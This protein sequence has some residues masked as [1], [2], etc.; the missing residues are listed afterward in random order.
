M[1]LRAFF[2]RRMMKMK[3]VIFCKAVIPSRKIKRKECFPDKSSICKACQYNTKKKSFKRTPKPKIYLSVYTKYPPKGDLFNA[4]NLPNQNILDKRPAY[5]SEMRTSTIPKLE[6]VYIPLKCA[7]MQFLKEKNPL[8]ALRLIALAN[9]AG[10]YPPLSVLKFLSRKIT[11]YFDLYGTVSLDKILGLTKKKG[12][13]KAFVKNLIRKRDQTLLLDISRLRKVFGLSIPE[14]ILMVK[15]RIDKT[16]FNETPYKIK[17]PS[18]N[19]LRTLYHRKKA[20]DYFSDRHIK[21]WTEVKKKNY[22]KKYPIDS[23]PNRI[24]KSVLKSAL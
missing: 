13:E 10:V 3:D 15:K 20:S 2:M 22:L 24:K 7:E 4:S 9:M 1:R 23:I 19:W 21:Q 14:A 18:E 11:E 5:I 16:P 17:K 8:E 12:Q 6:K